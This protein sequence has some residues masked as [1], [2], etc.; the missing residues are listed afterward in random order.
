MDTKPPGVT[1]VFPQ[2]VRVLGGFPRQLDRELADLRSPT[3]MPRVLLRK[4]GRTVMMGQGR[5]SRSLLWPNLHVLGCPGALLPL[6][7]DLVYL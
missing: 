2:G 5:G 1:S 3:R 7:N 6:F 4:L